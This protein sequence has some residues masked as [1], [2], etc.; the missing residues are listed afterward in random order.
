MTALENLGN[1]GKSWMT[2][3]EFFWEAD[4]YYNLVVKLAT[5]IIILIVYIKKL[6]W[7]YFMF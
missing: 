3:H 2:A 5:K 4:K 1:L 6:L 7:F